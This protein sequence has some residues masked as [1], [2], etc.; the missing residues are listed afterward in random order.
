VAKELN[1]AADTLD[2]EDDLIAQ[3]KQIY[4]QFYSQF[5]DARIEAKNHGYTLLI[6]D[7]VSEV[8]R[9]KY[10]IALLYYVPG[11]HVTSSCN[12]LEKSQ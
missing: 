8:A 2:G 9:R 3:S 7:S 11:K 4:A 12:V 6:S 10:A 1:I 5:E